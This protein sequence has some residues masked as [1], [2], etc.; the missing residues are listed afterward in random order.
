MLIVGSVILG[1]QFLPRC[2]ITI[3]YDQP[4]NSSGT[5]DDPENPTNPANPTDPAN[6]ANPTDTATP[7]NPVTPTN[8]EH[9]P[10]PS[11]CGPWYST[12]IMAIPE[13]FF[14][15]TS[16]SANWAAGSKANKVHAIGSLFHGIG[17][18]RRYDRNE[19]KD[20]GFGTTKFGT[21]PW[22]YYGEILELSAI[23]S[24][25]EGWR[26]TLGITVLCLGAILACC[27]REDADTP[28]GYR[29]CGGYLMEMVY[30]AIVVSAATEDW[31]RLLWILPQVPI[32]TV[33]LALLR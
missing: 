31:T 6:P 7:T 8:P 3:T 4:G 14:D 11:R 33:A 30:V 28:V 25:L 20:R 17:A 12:S 24:T 22:S 26:Q 13:I 9:R 29:R 5:V 32:E 15:V 23:V 10:E 19:G 1:L 27:C 18:A 2:T 21:T 16:A